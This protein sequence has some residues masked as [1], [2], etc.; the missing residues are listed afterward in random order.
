MKIRHPKRL[1]YRG[2]LLDC[3]MTEQ[4]RD[5][6]ISELI[7]RHQRQLYAGKTKAAESYFHVMAPVEMAM[8]RGSFSSQGI[9]T[10]R[11]ILLMLFIC[12]LTCLSSNNPI[13]GICI[14]ADK[15]DSAYQALANTTCPFGG[16]FYDYGTG[17]YGSG[18]LISPN[19]ILTARH[20]IG[21]SRSCF[22]AM[23]NSDDYFSQTVTNSNYDIALCKLV[24]PITNITPVKL[25]SVAKYG[26]E[27]G[28]ECY[29]SGDG[30]TG[31]GLTGMIGGFWVRRAA[32]S[33]VMCNATSWGWGDSLLTQFRSPGNGAA[34]L[35]GDGVEGDSGGGL[36]LSVSGTLALA[37]IQSYAWWNGS[38]MGYYG[39]GAGY[40]R[41][42]TADTLSWIRSYVID[43]TIVDIPEP[44]SITLLVTC[45]L[46]ICGN[47][48]RRH[49]NR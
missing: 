16:I 30:L 31:T 40:I 26:D 8:I 28:K 33:Y 12:G 36:Y 27:V 14:R 45:V 6:P 37:G 42:G 2:V 24:T 25:Y 38:Q 10:M 49:R 48:L 3:E 4:E 9:K 34:P 7:A 46:C 13:W 21:G 11:S 19:W 43:A 22:M 39:D 47:R 15:D 17:T 41:T 20:A 44:S 29:I 1:L 35:E 32:Q 23:N 5:D 18:V